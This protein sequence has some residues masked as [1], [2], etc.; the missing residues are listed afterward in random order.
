MK[1][2]WLAITVIILLVVTEIKGA[3][4]EKGNTINIS[5]SINDDL[6]TGGDEITVNATVN[7]DL[8]GYGRVFYLNDT[9]TGDV[10]VASEQ[11]EVKGVVLDDIRFAGRIIRISGEIRGD[12]IVF[13]AEVIIDKG[14]KVYGDIVLNAGKVTAGGTVGGSARIRSET[15][16]IGGSIAEGGDIKASKALSVYGEIKGRSAI[17]SNSIQLNHD[18]AR[19]DGDVE[20]WT[21]KGEMN[22]GNTL[23]GGKALYNPDL[24]VEKRDYMGLYPQAFFLGFILLAFLC[25]LFFHYLFSATFLGAASHLRAEPVKSLGWGALYFFGMPALIFLLV[26]MIIGIFLAIFLFFFYLFSIFFGMVITSLVISD[27]IRLKGN[28]EWGFWQISFI[29]LLVLVVMNILFLVPVI[30]FLAIVV[31]TFMAFGSIILRL[32]EKRRKAIVSD[33]GSN[34]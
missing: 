5:E 18:R 26:M 2:A 17:A 27:Y 34:G 10:V 4:F 11:M 19:F 14:A 20:Y 22:F 3:V 31:L 6:Y 12:L 7:G 29:A 25:L 13:A 1:S 9:I 23:V 30:G 32:T 8:I 28:K 16:N 15:A 21:E 33:A 24:A